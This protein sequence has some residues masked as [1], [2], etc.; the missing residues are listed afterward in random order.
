MARKSR[1]EQ[2]SGYTIMLV[3][4]NADYLQ[5]TRLLLER[6]GHHVLTATNGL[7][8][9]ALL[10]AQK[11]DLLL[12]DYYMPGLTGEQV[13]T[14][15]RKAHP[16][17]QVILQTGYASEQPPQELLRR[18][19]I[20]GYYDK[21]D[22][23][24]QLLLW[25]AVGL[26]AA[27]TIDV[28]NRSREGLHQ[29]LEGTPALHRIQPLPDLLESALLGVTQLVTTIGRP[30]RADAAQRPE[31]FVA[32]VDH[33]GALGEM[34][35]TGRFGS[36]RDVEPELAL[37]IGQAL[38]QGELLVSGGATIVPLR[39][40]GVG[41]GVICLFCSG[42]LD[43][44]LHM[45]RVFADQAAVAIQN[46]LLF[47]LVDVD[48]GTGL[49]A[50][51]L[52]DGAVVRAASTALRWCEPL[53]LVLLGID[54]PVASGTE[55]G[56]RALEAAVAVLGAKLRDV[57]R[58]GDLAA[59]FGVGELAVLV[60]HPTEEA[61]VGLG[62]RL[63]AITARP[64]ATPAGEV[65]VRSSVGHA[66]LLPHRFAPADAA[67]RL[68]PAYFAAVRD[69]LVTRARSAL[70]DARQAGGGASGAGPLSWPPLPDAQ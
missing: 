63:T 4:D 55:D 2:P 16:Y 68:P 62:R 30:G 26:K 39:V 50:R 28:L 35:G 61:M 3:D 20:Q 11:V 38:E 31:G 18:L 17:V 37:A 40:G 41:V 67:R 65:T 44:A 42:V 7:E 5:A 57:L 19:D 34:V 49:Y 64:L 48:V 27:Y 24:E 70:L 53:G 13:V 23:P 66:L 10:P 54:E 46:A 33:A 69:M 60:H 9:L 14:E 21:T 43:Q 47:D 22:G 12:L 15:I 1:A 6:D 32:L 29:I 25:T 56:R 59:R 8:A 36:T 51:S 52:L 45:L 58:A